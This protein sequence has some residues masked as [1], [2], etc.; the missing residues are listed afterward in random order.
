MAP[1]V[2]PSTTNLFL[3][4]AR[5]I[6]ILKRQLKFQVYILFSLF[7]PTF[8]NEINNHKSFAFGTFF[9]AKANVVFYHQRQW[10]QRTTPR[11]FFLRCYFKFD[12]VEFENI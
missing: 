5:D 8:N 9:Y 12:R 2:S 7:S 4:R 6:Q 11:I 1:R 10:Q 3:R